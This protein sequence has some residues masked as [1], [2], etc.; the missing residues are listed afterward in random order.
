M[1]N[2]KRPK[3]LLDQDIGFYFEYVIKEAEKWSKAINTFL[4]RVEK[5]NSLVDKNDSIFKEFKAIVKNKEISIS[6]PK[7]NE[8]KN[9]KSDYI[10]NMTYLFDYHYSK[11]NYIEDTVE[12]LIF[13]AIQD[14]YLKCIE[15][16]SQNILIVSR[17]YE[18]EIQQKINPLLKDNNMLNIPQISDVYIEFLKFIDKNIENINIE[19]KNEVGHILLECIEDMVDIVTVED[20]TRIKGIF[21]PPKNINSHFENESFNDKYFNL[22]KEYND[23]SN[24]STDKIKNQ[25]NIITAKYG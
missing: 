9:R 19:K 14:H 17:N 11:E 15:N 10:K 7:K 1:N 24:L 18:N 6:L 2:D 21:N 25:L 8:L 23:L 5:Y 16:L 13:T 20:S 3:L 4:K 12:K 22:I